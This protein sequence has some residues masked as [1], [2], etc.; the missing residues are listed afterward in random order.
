MTPEVSVALFI[1]PPS[2]HF[3]QDRLFDP[4]VAA[5]AGDDINAPYRHLRELCNHR[6][7]PVH[8]I[9]ALLDGRVRAERSICV[10]M[11]MLEHYEEVRRRPG[12]VLSAYFAMDCPIVEPRL[13][14]GLPAAAR[15]FRRVY[16]WST[17]RALLPFTKTAVQ[18]EQF[19]WPQSFDGVH[20]QL[21][22]REER[23]FL[24]MINANKLPRLY[25]NELYTHRL[26]AVAHFERT[27][28]IDLY[29]K[30]WDEAPRRLGRTWVPWTLRIWGEK[31]WELRQ[32][33]R[34]RP[35]YAATRRAW[36]GTASSKS[37]TLGR[38]R[39][40]ICFENMVLEG[41][42][43][44]KLFDCFFAGTVPVYLGAPDVLDHVPKE[45]FIDFREFAGFEELRL[46]LRSL[47]GAR[48]RDYRDAARAYLE[49]PRFDPFRKETFARRFLRLIDEDALR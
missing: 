3:L 20:E 36:R 30:G 23:D 5:T 48:V 13:F 15:A 28:E 46:F 44:E 35:V 41:W 47:S 42:M 10:S 25:V 27:G 1:D 49:S 26:A 9:D 24:V 12:T 19:R 45:C 43:T 2:H 4:G 6:G 34:P 29:G 7:I 39:F 14:W 11:G 33:V 38:Y 40:S 22:A 18:V 21:W 8:T 16:S 32:R 37:A 17:S 31:L